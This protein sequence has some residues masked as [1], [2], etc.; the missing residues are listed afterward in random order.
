M[1]DQTEE[2][3]VTRNICAWAYATAE[4]ADRSQKNLEHE[5]IKV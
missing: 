5:Q 4:S 1:L 3:N 2:K